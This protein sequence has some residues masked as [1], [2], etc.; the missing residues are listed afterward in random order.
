MA[1]KPSEAAPAEELAVDAVQLGWDLLSSPRTLVALSA[2]LGTVVFAGALVVQGA[3]STELMAHHSFGVAHNIERLGFQHVLTAWPTLLLA[4]LIVLNLVGITLRRTFGIG[5]GLSERSPRPA[6]ATSREGVVDLDKAAM[7]AALDQHVGGKVW[8]RSDGALVARR[9]LYSEAGFGI[10][11]GLAMLAI[12]VGVGRGAF[13]ARMTLIAGADKPEEAALST[14]VREGGDWIER[15]VPLAVTCAGADPMDQWRR[16]EC[17]L[18]E[19]DGGRRPF[20]ATAGQSAKVGDLVITVER[21]A[22]VAG[23]LRNQVALLLE[24]EGKGPEI[25]RGEVGRT[26]RLQTGEALTSFVGP[27]GPFTVVAAAEGR[28]TLMAPALGRPKAP[29]PSGLS[30]S[31]IP[32][33]RV[34]VALSSDPARFF[35]LGGVITLVLALLLRILV[36]HLLLIARRT[37]AGYRVL[38]VSYNRRRL[39]EATLE[40]LRRAGDAS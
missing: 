34:Q 1:T 38:L 28:P 23:A 9:G 30:L 2:L 17:V 37:P 20:L 36:P 33:Y 16:R 21:E 11:A 8:T 31:G 13:E 14:E 26:F 25:H 40:A 32:P 18:L 3:T 5:A 12:A 4:L 22:P 7:G 24:R 29:A 35:V 27:D 6:L 39:P 19:G 10:L 15:Q